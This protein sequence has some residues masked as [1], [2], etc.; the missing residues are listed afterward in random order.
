IPEAGLRAGVARFPGVTCGPG[1]VARRAHT[2]GGGF[3]GHYNSWV[4]RPWRGTKY[5]EG[6]D[7]DRVRTCRVSAD[8]CE[9]GGRSFAAHGDYGRVFPGG[10]KTKTHPGRRAS[11]VAWGDGA[12]GA[13]GKAVGGDPG[14]D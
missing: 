5:D 9:P 11:A 7:C 3:G 6:S 2:G 1:G 10:K 14:G 8:D 4:R 12:A 13:G